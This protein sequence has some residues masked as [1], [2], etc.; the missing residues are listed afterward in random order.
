MV[1]TRE[2]VIVQSWDYFPPTAKMT[3]DHLHAA[4][5]N[6]LGIMCLIGEVL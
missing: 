3:N 4:Y 6:L 5:E 1:G 2:Q